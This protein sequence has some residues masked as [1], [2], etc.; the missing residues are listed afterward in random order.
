MKAAKIQEINFTLLHKK[1][2][3]TSFE[4]VTTLFEKR[5]ILDY[6]AALE[7]KSKK[8]ISNIL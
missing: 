7:M 4:N 5:T 8:L 3:N 6:F 1:A 2:Y